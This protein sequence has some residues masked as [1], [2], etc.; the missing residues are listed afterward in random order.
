MY[1]CLVNN[2]SHHTQEM[3]TFLRQTYAFC[4]YSKLVCVYVLDIR[5]HIVCCQI[6][7]GYPVSSTNIMQWSYT[8]TCISNTHPSHGIPNASM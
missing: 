6:N 8:R 7:K 2:L 5:W 3:L 1:Q 4:V